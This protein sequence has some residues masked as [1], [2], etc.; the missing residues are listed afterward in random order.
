M[1]KQERIPT[2]KQL[3]KMHRQNQASGELHTLHMAWLQEEFRPTDMPMRTMD[4]LGRE[5][6]RIHKEIE[7][8]KTE[9]IAERFT[10]AKE[11]AIAAS[12]PKKRVTY[13]KTVD[14]IDEVLKLARVWYQAEPRSKQ[15]QMA[16]LDTLRLLLSRV[17]AGHLDDLEMR[18]HQA[19]L[20]PTPSA[21][22]QDS[23]I[24]DREE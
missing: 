22:K 18:F 20:V 21:E 7:A 9:H 6:K 19:A 4:S 16:Q 2:Q 13:L 17:A 24:Q 1:P 14:A 10:Q 5:V 3:E 15:D 23:I 12:L 11:V 8:G